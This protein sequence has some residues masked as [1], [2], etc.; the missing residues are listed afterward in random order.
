MPFFTVRHFEIYRLLLS[1]LVGNSILSII[2]ILLSYPA[3]A[4]KMEYSSGSGAFLSLLLMLTVVTNIFFALL[5]YILYL[6]N[7]FAEAIFWRSSGFFTTLFSL[8]TIECMMNPDAPRRLMFI[9]V[10]IPSKYFPLALYALFSIFGGPELSFLVSIFVGYLYCKGQ[11]DRLKPTSYQLEQLEATGAGPGGYLRGIFHS[12]SRSKGWVLAGAAL[13]HDAWIA[14]NANEV[15]ATNSTS[16]SS[17]GG[18]GFPS[19]SSAT[20]STA[21]AAKPATK[22]LFPGAGKTAG[23]SSSAGR[24]YGALFS[25]AAASTSSTSSSTSGSAVVP[26]REELAARRLAAMGNHNV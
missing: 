26:S 15:R 16:T 25:G 6:F 19:F 20:T 8:I 7:V 18:S 23:G 13:G 10:D 1:P 3:T 2:I 17:S 5:C 22:E 24:S 11:L 21:T 14:V 4:Q 12:L 9:P